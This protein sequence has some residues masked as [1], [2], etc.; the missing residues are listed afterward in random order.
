[1]NLKIMVTVLHGLKLSEEFQVIN[2]L[3]SFPR[4]LPTLKV[5]AKKNSWHQLRLMWKCS[6]RSEA[7][8]LSPRRDTT[9]IWRQ[10]LAELRRH[11][12]TEC[13]TF[14]MCFHSWGAIGFQD[15]SLQR[16]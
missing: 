2:S 14:H 8:S 16:M 4:N 3:N 13:K 10:H 1:M 12:S 5:G 11:S 15:S 6:A 7:A 9:K